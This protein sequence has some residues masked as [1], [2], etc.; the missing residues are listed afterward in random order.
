MKRGIV[1]SIENKK[2]VVMTADGQFISIP[3]QSHMRI[4][5]ET[6]IL[7]ETAVPRRKPKRIYWYTGAA[8]A[9]LLFFIPFFY[10][11]TAEAHPVVAYVS[12]DINPSIE[13]G[14]DKQQRVQELNGLNS[15]GQAIVSKLNYKGKPLEAVAA[16]IMS[17]VAAEHYLDK[18]D[19]DIVITSLMLDDKSLADDLERLVTTA[20]D[21]KVKETIKQ[22][23]ATKVPNVTVLSVPNEVR[24]E[25]SANGISSG[26]MAVYLMAKDE[27][28]EIELEQMKVQ[29][30]AEAT[31]AAGGV[32]KIVEQGASK[33]RL[34][35]LAQKE[36]Q[37]K[38]AA[39]PA[40][41][42]AKPAKAGTV[43]E[44]NTTKTEPAKPTGTKP[45]PPAKPSQ[46]ERP[47]WSKDK[48]HNWNK[49]TR[50][51][52]PISPS[53]PSGSDK[54]KWP[55]GDWS[56]NRKDWNEDS[57]HDDDKKNDSN[58]N[59]T[60][61]N[62]NKLENWSWQNEDNDRDNDRNMDRNND[63]DKDRNNNKRDDSDDRRD[64]DR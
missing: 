7:A 11:T 24:E 10:L 22:I 6:A 39:K 16:S 47:G 60:A 27:G 36:K 42:Q 18:P 20:I 26:K 13:L 53:K 8:A 58:N 40:A 56:N 44:K 14:L 5:E 45:K 63:R 29:S 3:H 9:I 55:N 31:Q 50:P 49:P 17:T 62:S 37:S 28:Y 38:K 15:D 19:K 46:T 2:A 61:N 43:P 30:I 51:V 4:G 21:E 32:K 59:N 54:D 23:D 41:D 12:L 33:E 35:E 25:A 52:K 1:L 34:K 57:Y 64:R 48:N